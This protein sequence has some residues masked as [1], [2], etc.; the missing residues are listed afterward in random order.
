M[1]A[2][3]YV[4]SDQERVYL[5]KIIDEQHRIRDERI[6]VIGVAALE[7][8]LMEVSCS[9]APGLVDRFNSGSH[10]DMDFFTFVRSS[11]ALSTAM[12]AFAEAGWNHTGT[13]QQLLPILRKIG[14]TAEK[15]MFQA[16]NGINT[17]KGILFLLGILSAATALVARERYPIIKATMILSESSRICQGLVQNE[18]ETIKNNKIQRE[19]TAGEQFY[20][21]YGIT[22]IRGEIESGLP[23]VVQHALPCFQEALTKGLSLNDALIHTLLSLMSCTDD[24]TILNRHNPETLWSVKEEAA[25][26]LEDGGMF[27]VCGRKRI[28]ELDEYYVKHNISPGGSADLLA[29]TYF[30]YVIEKRL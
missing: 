30:L 3:P 17:Q 4:T 13:S 11:S 26:I 23:G 16:T 9:P 12:I 2:L 10:R 28:N 7:A 22:G 1:S 15:K 18:L 25:S 20:V 24:T 5:G 8:M 27:T 19:R 6:E 21:K 14:I 29:A